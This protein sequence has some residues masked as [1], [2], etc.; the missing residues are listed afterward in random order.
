[1]VA[2]TLAI[3]GILIQKKM[4]GKNDVPKASRKDA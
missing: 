2:F 4:P 1:M 3:T